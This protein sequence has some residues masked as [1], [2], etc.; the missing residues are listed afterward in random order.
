M[1]IQGMLTVND[2]A[3]L[4]RTTPTQVRHM[5]RRG[6]I[7]APKKIPGLGLRWA[8]AVMKSWIAENFSGEGVTA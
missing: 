7:P 4:V 6:Q 2:V 8:A 1:D 5:A 3:G